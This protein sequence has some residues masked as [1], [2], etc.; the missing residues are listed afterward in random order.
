MEGRVY[1][2]KYKEFRRKVF[3]RDGHKCQMPGCKSRSKKFEI[4]HILKWA[5]FPSLRYDP[6]N[7]IVLHKTCHKKIKNKE[8]IYAPMFA[9]IVYRNSR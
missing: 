3:A 9:E 1:D 7:G 5:K 8:D 2:D 6:K 4:H